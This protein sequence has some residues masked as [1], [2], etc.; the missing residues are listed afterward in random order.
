MVVGFKIG[1]GT[2]ATG[3]ALDQQETMPLES[4]GDVEFQRLGRPGDI[5]DI[6][7]PPEPIMA[8]VFNELL[9]NVPRAVDP[10]LQHKKAFRALH[11][12]GWAWLGCSGQELE[13]V[14]VK[15]QCLA[16]GTEAASG[17]QAW[18]CLLIS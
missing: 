13:C 12:S 10:R 7:N 11:K 18:I 17:I 15:S 6:P 9:Q 1:A 14:A 8:N 4:A 2:V 5:P 16:P 3:S